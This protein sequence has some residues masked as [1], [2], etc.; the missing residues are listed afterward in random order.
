MGTNSDYGVIMIAGIMQRAGTN[1][2]A[3]LLAIHPGCV[4][5]FASEPESLWGSSQVSVV[6]EQLITQF[7]KQ[8][9]NGKTDISSFERFILPTDLPPAANAAECGGIASGGGDTSNGF[10]EAD[11]DE[12]EQG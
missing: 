2:L 8:V 10:D 4:K 1:F 9:Q 5:S 7:H 3:D 11:F 12:A 6:V